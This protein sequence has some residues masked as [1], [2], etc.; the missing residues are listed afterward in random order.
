MCRVST[1]GVQKWAS[2]AYGKEIGMLAVVVLIIFFVGLALFIRSMKRNS[3]EIK[4][5]WKEGWD[6]GG[7]N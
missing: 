7:Q 4:R 3:S 6:K 2:F 1:E 5:A